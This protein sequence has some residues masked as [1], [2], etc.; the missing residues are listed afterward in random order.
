MALL[1]CWSGCLEL[2]LCSCAFC[3]PLQ[4]QYILLTLVKESLQTC[5]LWRAL[6][7][8]R[9]ANHCGRWTWC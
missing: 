5:P 8:V 9:R 1:M 4:L 6:T 2:D 3:W 7:A